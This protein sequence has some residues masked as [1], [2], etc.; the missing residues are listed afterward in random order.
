VVYAIDASHRRLDA[1]RQLPNTR[2]RAGIERLDKVAEIVDEVAREVI[3]RRASGDTGRPDVLLMFGDLTQLGRRL[4]ESS[5]SPTLD[6]LLV[7]ASGADVGI[8]V[9]GS[10]ARSA[11][12]CGLSDV[13][14]R[15][16]VGALSS[17]AD[18]MALGLDF[19]PLVRFG[20]GRCRELSTGRLVQLATAVGV[21]EHLSGYSTSS[22][23]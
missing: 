22:P 23:R 8:N 20:T 18:A 21:E 19:A 1:I 12:S 5:Y 3:D 14:E 11:D 13:I 15:K 16:F 7:A 17:A 9:V 2:E 4:S 6:R 10:A